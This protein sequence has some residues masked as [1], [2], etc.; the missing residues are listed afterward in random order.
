MC[1]IE[2]QI[3]K[4]CDEPEAVE[5]PECKSSMTEHLTDLLECDECP[6]TEFKGDDNE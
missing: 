1:G 4:H 5:C 2:K 3:A 6:H